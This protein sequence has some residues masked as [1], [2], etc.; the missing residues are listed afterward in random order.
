MKVHCCLHYFLNLFQA[1][2]FDHSKVNAKLITKK[3][4]V[5]YGTFHHR[6]SQSKT[7]RKVKG[8]GHASGGT[9]KSRKLHKGMFKQNHLISMLVYLNCRHTSVSGYD[10][11]PSDIN[12][13]YAADEDEIA[14]VII[15]FQRAG[16]PIT[17]PKL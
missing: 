14:Q 11:C 7:S 15:D 9:H 10:K 6:V 16:F 17:V 4:W 13:I 3:H 8:S 1:N 12:F 2:N 5:K